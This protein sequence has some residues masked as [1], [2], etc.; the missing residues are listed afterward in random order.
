[1]VETTNIS[2]RSN[3]M[4]ATKE[5]RIKGSTVEKAYLSISNDGERDVSADK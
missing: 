4:D 2:G 5:L 1:M 3:G